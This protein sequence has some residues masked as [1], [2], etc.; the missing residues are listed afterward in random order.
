[1]GAISEGAALLA[2]IDGAFGVAGKKIDLEIAKHEA[3]ARKEQNIALTN[4]KIKAGIQNTM[5]QNDLAITRQEYLSSVNDL[6][7]KIQEGEKLNVINSDFMNLNS[8]QTTEDG[9]FLLNAV[10]QGTINSLTTEYSEVEGQGNTLDKLNEAIRLNNLV[11]DKIDAGIKES[12][13]YTLAAG[14]VVD[15]ASN[16][17]F[18]HNDDFTKSTQVERF[19]EL[20][21]DHEVDADGNL[22]P[23]WNARFQVYYNALPT[24]LEEKA[25]IQEYLEPQFEALKAGII[26]K[27][28]NKAETIENGKAGFESWNE[29]NSNA[30]STL[31]STMAQIDTEDDLKA[32]DFV[33]AENKHLFDFEWAEKKDAL[34]TQA[35]RV[36]LNEQLRAA[37]SHI[38]TYGNE[39]SVFENE[40]LVELAT[41]PNRDDMRML[42][43]LFHIPINDEGGREGYT[44]A[45]V[46]SEDEW[47]GVAHVFA[48]SGKDRNSKI[49]VTGIDRGRSNLASKSSYD[50]SNIHH[51]MTSIE[52][53]EAVLSKWLGMSDSDIS[54]FE[55]SWQFL[56]LVDSG[57]GDKA[58]PAQNLSEEYL[59]SLFDAYHHVES[60]MQFDERVNAFADGF[61][62]T[63]YT[64]ASGMTFTIDENMVANMKEDFLINFGLEY[65]DTGMLNSI[66]AIG[67]SAL[68]KD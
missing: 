29:D 47:A 10:N 40:K 35:A 38:I 41:S 11:S 34:T 44:Y 49:G 36:K 61:L 52:D 19:K 65:A 17:F 31:V 55:G 7:T 56:D 15:E 62:G 66:D 58:G 26:E 59:V 1:M 67:I 25:V 14:Q 64:D 22:T 9:A 8:E 57:G 21:I 27:S 48:P 37:I 28:D 12:D 6:E 50:L 45:D 63:A 54:N 13:T 2:I 18:I 46:Y 4:M 43:K 32:Y 33:N 5:L 16:D 20:F 53:E 24:T 42:M 68:H 51:F 23:I 60:T 3:N 30:I 39:G